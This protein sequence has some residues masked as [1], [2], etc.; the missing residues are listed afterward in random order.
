MIICGIC[1][2][3]WQWAVFLIH[4]FQAFWSVRVFLT[5]C[6]QPNIKHSG[7]ERLLYFPVARWRVSLKVCIVSRSDYFEES[8]RG[9]TLV[10][11]NNPALLAPEKYRNCQ[12][13]FNI[14]DDL[15][16]AVEEKQEATLF[17]YFITRSTSRLPLSSSTPTN[18]PNN[19]SIRWA[20]KSWQLPRLIVLLYRCD[21]YPASGTTRWF[22]VYSRGSNNGILPL[23]RL[24]KDV[25]LS[26]R[27]SSPVH[28]LNAPSLNWCVF[29]IFLSLFERCLTL[30]QL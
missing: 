3:L 23:S 2:L 6:S 8:V 4:F 29:L 5:G 7:I 16:I 9:K 19:G 11:V 12:V 26:F 14:I 15:M 18:P 1:D 21:T 20:T 28:K 22:L 10:R 30:C 25:Q 17:L 24:S 13:R 27:F